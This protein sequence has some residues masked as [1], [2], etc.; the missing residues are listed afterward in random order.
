MTDSGAGSDFLPSLQCQFT[1]S[2]SAVDSDSITPSSQVTVADSGILANESVTTVG[3]LTVTVT[4]EGKGAEFAC[5]I[6]PS[7]PMIDGLALPHVL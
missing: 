6:K 1:I 7:S 3:N 4:D 2:D 5:R